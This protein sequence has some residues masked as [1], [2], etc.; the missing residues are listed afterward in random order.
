M[1]TPTRGVPSV[2]SLLPRSRSRMRGP[3]AVIVTG[4]RGYERGLEFLAEAQTVAAVVIKAGEGLA[5][6][7]AQTRIEAAGGRIVPPHFQRDR[8]ASSPARAHFGLPD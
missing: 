6:L 4:T 7:I 1:A 8:V 3:L 5:L 2:S